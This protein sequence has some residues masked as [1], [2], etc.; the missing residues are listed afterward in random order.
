MSFKDNLPEDIRNDKTLE[1]FEDEASL[2]K[3]YIELSRMIG[4]SIRVPGEGASEEEV[5]KI[6]E[7]VSHLG[8]GKLPKD[9]DEVLDKLLKVPTKAEELKID[10]DK[11]LL[12]VASEEQA[13]HLINRAIELKLTNKQAERFL[14]A[15]LKEIKA[16]KEG[17]KARL[18]EAESKIKEMFGSDFEARTRGMELAAKVVAEKVP[19]FEEFAQSDASK[20]PAVAFML[21]E[22]AK[23][24][25]EG[26][27]ILGKPAVQYGLTPSEAQAK[28]ESLR[29]H[30][31][32][33]NAYHPDHDAVVEERAKLMKIAFASEG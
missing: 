10:I 12:G 15:N 6:L 17:R 21:S 29:S 28:L 23:T 30:E 18:T 2:A 7:K 20:H 24:L 9:E 1:K 33:Y 19:G 8:I 4:N 26:N 31:A 11:D 16:E 25:K 14:T 27:A 3:S 5:S 13:A 22:M 32:Y